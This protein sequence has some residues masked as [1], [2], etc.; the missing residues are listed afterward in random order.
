[1]SSGH[2]GHAREECKTCATRALFLSA[3]ILSSFA[4]AG[5]GVGIHLGQLSRARISARKSFVVFF[6][7][8]ER[9]EVRMVY[10]T[11]IFMMEMRR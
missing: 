7:A 6:F 10:F 2:V 8:T 5:G 9:K 1:M 3:N 4:S 11:E